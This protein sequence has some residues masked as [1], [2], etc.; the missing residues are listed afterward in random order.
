MGWKS[1]EKPKTMQASKALVTEFYNMERLPRERPMS[2]RRLMV[3]RRILAAGDF[4]PVTWARAWCKDESVMYR[5]NGQ[6]TSTLLMGVIESDQEL[7]PFFVTV[8]R[9]ECDTMEDVA[10]L[11]ATF[12]SSIGSRNSTDIILSFASTMPEINGLPSK[13]Y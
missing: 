1:I 9:Y 5:V 12:D 7:P 3:Y 8:E 13:V 6:H 4:R 2:E 11:Y 10:R